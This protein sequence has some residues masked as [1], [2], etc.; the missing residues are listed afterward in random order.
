MQ[1][2]LTVMSSVKICVNDKCIDGKNISLAPWASTSCNALYTDPP[3]TPC[4]SRIE[5][6]DLLNTELNVI[7]SATLGQELSVSVQQV[8]VGNTSIIRVVYVYRDTSTDEYSVIGARLVCKDAT[9]EDLV[10][11][12]YQMGTHVQK[13]AS[14]VLVV[15]WTIDL[16]FTVM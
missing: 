8:S 10:V 6:I 16:L 5:R 11:H 15:N 13:T 2:K 3:V 9:G 1:E 4:A 14:D 12:F 7:K